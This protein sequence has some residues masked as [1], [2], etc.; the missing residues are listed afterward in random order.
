MYVHRG[1][2]FPNFNSKTTKMAS[3]EDLYSPYP[4]K[5][6]EDLT[7]REHFAMHFFAVRRSLD[8]TLGSTHVAKWAVIDADALLKALAEKEA[9]HV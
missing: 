3:N 1:C 9:S 8:A 6:P 7:K 2:S 4:S 5:K